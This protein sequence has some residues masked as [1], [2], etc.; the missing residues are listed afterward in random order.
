MSKYQILGLHLNS[1]LVPQ[2]DVFF[3][4]FL[5]TD[6]NQ[7]QLFFLRSFYFLLHHFLQCGHNKGKQKQYIKYYTHTISHNFITTNAIQ[8]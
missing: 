1:S 3:F 4:F 5:L 7:R 6:S 2:A 8:T